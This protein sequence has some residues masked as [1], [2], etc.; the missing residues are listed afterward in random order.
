MIKNDMEPKKY[1]Y[2][3]PET[4]ENEEISKETHDFMQRFLPRVKKGLGQVFVASTGD[5]RGDQFR[6]L[7]MAKL[8][9]I[10]DDPEVNALRF[11]DWTEKN[12]PDK[13]KFDGS[14]INPLEND[15]IGLLP[16]RKPMNLADLDFICNKTKAYLHSF[17]DAKFDIANGW[18]DFVRLASIH[19]NLNPPRRFF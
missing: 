6:E 3:N 16:T 7:Y 2:N 1:Y 4:G 13:L 8:D 18:A 14:A 12:I 10:S 17:I 15:E 19:R 9:P 11:T 5:I